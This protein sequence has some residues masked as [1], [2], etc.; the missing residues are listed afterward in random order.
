MYEFPQISSTMIIHYQT[1]EFQN[2]YR[3]IR[4]MFQE[5]FPNTLFKC[6]E[7]NFSELYG[8]DIAVVKLI[9][10]FALITSS[11]VAWVFSHSLLSWL[12]VKLGKSPYVK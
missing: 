3:Y 1:G 2:V 10:L 4:T 11:L 6:E 12:K 5:K 7:Y 9:I 8:K